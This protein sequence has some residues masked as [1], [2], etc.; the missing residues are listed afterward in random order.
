MGDVSNATPWGICAGSGSCR[1]QR[2]K[3]ST[4]TLSLGGLNGGLGVNGGGGV[5]S[6]REHV[7][8]L[9]TEDSG[10]AMSGD[11]GGLRGGREASG[12]GG[13]KL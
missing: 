5:L 4:V 8:K 11:G 3:R 7:S 10:S 12:D 9:Q 6:G 2:W 13:V 1:V